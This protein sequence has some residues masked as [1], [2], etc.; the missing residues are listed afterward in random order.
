MTDT[1]DL[2]EQPTDYPGADALTLDANAAAG[3]LYEI[4]GTEMTVAASR[5]THCGNRAQVGTLR[6]YMHAP[7]LVLRCSI[8]TEIVIRV[9]R[10]PDG[11]FLVDA[12]GA[13]YL[14]M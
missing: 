2:N 12:R 14:R 11:T 4:F 10:R 13:A 7:G 1:S 8:C 6:A 3:M 5:C 9:M